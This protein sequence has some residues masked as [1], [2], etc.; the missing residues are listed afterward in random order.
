MSRLGHLSESTLGHLSEWW[1]I[2]V[3]HRR[4]LGRTIIGMSTVSHLD[5]AAR[6]AARQA[7]R[8]L[9]EPADRQRIR[10]AAG[11]TRSDVAELIGVTRQCV[12]AWENGRIRPQGQ[13]GTDYA[14]LLRELRA[15]SVVA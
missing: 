1:R 7:A 8:N 6:V 9:P 15:L 2:W 13:R 12:W 3:F 4:I 5:V 14:V 11:L 10:E